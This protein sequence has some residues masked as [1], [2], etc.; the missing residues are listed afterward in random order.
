MST[1]DRRA[2]G[3]TRIPFEALVEVGGALGPSFEAQAIDISEEGMHLRTAYLPE[4][5]QP[6]SCRFEAGPSGNVI[7]SGE[8]VW[9]QEAGKGGEFGIRFTDLDAQSAE[10]LRGMMGVGEAP[11]LQKGNRVR[12]HIEGL[13]SPMRAHVKKT[14]RGQ[15]TA[16][17]GLGFLQ[18]GKHLELEDANTGA[19]RPAHVTRVECE[20]DPASHVPQLVMSFQYEDEQGMRESMPAKEDTPEP[21]VTHEEPAASPEPTAKTSA[22]NAEQDAIERA[23]EEMKGALARGA[24]KITPALEQLLKRAKTTV[25]LLAAK[26][27]GGSGDD[28][29]VPLRRRTSPPPQGGLHASGRKVI[30]ESIQDSKEIPPEPTPGSRKSK[31]VGLGAAAVGFIALSAIAVHKLSTPADAAADANAATGPAAAAPLT[32][33]TAEAPQTAPPSVLA[34]VTPTMPPANNGASYSTSGASETGTNDVLDEETESHP[35]HRIHVAPF[36][37]GPVAHGNVLRI[38]MDGAIEKIEGDAQPAGFTVVIPGRKSLE[39]AAPLAARDGRIASI[40]VTNDGSGAELTVAFKDG[41]PNYLVRA[42]G[43]V[44]EMVLAP[45]GSLSAA[46]KPVRATSAPAPRHHRHPR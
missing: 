41:V 2:A 26:R 44:L 14:E 39:P 11:A 13:G 33:A 20:I 35:R 18:V 15:L 27:S 19:K 25:A 17:S 6:L 3:A 12:L 40:R 1:D 5:G 36:S 24:S 10:A 21:M 31:R 32:P 30:R 46:T 28:V 23:S 42:K 7:A 37:N 43:D 9:K 29:A 8:V 4:V 45:N 34:P 16:F 22:P 38:K